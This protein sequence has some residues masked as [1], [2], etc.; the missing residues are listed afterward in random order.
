MFKAPAATPLCCDQWPV[1]DVALCGKE[2]QEPGR[3]WSGGRGRVMLNDEQRQTLY[4]H[5]LHYLR[6]PTLKTASATDKD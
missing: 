3:N 2:L 5:T 4:T 1:C 6:N